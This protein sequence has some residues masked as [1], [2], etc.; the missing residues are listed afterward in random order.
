MEKQY[1]DTGCIK[2]EIY[3][4]IIYSGPWVRFLENIF[5]VPYSNVLNTN[6][7]RIQKYSSHLCRI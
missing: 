7:V 4:A 5:F 1:V 6:S 3:E 2:R